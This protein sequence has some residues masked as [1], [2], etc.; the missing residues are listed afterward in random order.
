MARR[1]GPVISALSWSGQKSASS[2]CLFRLAGNHYN[3]INVF[4]VKEVLQCP[5]LTLLPRAQSGVR[6][7]AHI[8]GGTLPIMI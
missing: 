1:N 7:V 6:G 5:K 3:G 8:R 2:C 4:K